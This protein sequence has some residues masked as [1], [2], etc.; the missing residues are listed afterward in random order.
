MDREDISQPRRNVSPQ[1][2]TMGSMAEIKTIQPCL[3]LSHFLLFA[4]PQC[5]R[6][7]N[8]MHFRVDPPCPSPYITRAILSTALQVSCPSPGPMIIST[9]PHISFSP[10][11]AHHTT[12]PS[13]QQSPLQMYPIFAPHRRWYRENL[14]QLSPSVMLRRRL[15]LLTVALVARR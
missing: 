13:K 15:D 10:P 11:G 4:H 6:L 5:Q 1:L 7:L 14:V 9:T 3:A 2:T 12:S 8:L